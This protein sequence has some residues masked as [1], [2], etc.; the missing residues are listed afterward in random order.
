VRRR[1]E[2][3][4]EQFEDKEKS[5]LGEGGFE[6]AVEEVAKLEAAFGIDDLA[7]FTP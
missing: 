1:T 5:V 7:R 4:G 2:E 3:L 6:K